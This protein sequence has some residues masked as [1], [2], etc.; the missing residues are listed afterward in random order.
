LSYWAGE[1][2]LIVAEVAG[3]RGWG[4]L[5]YLVGVFLAG[6]IGDPENVRIG[7]ALRDGT[8]WHP[9]MLSD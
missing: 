4:C 5:Q 2:A 7:Q 1:V 3:V 8:V 6:G 9:S